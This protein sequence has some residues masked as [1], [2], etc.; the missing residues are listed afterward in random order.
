MS[1]WFTRRLSRREMQILGWMLSGCLLFCGL[2][3]FF[4]WGKTQLDTG[5]ALCADTLRFHIRAESDSLLDQSAKLR[6]RDA[7]LA[8]CAAAVM[9]DDKKRAEARRTHFALDG[10]D[11]GEHGNDGIGGLLDKWG[12]E[13][14]GAGK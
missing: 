9:E 3:Q 10:F 12:I 14:S 2:V 1:V 5:A 4:G 6:V 7:V 11:H 13:T 8:V